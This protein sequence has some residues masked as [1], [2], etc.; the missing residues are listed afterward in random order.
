MEKIFYQNKMFQ[1]KRVTFTL[2]K[3][4]V[5]LMLASSLV[6]ANKLASFTMQPAKTTEEVF[7]AAQ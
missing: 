3:F 4:A 5:S 7:S 6:L 2:K 1:F